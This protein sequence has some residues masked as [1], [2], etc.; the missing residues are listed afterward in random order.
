MPKWNGIWTNN[1]V[2]NLNNLRDATNYSGR[3]KVL[4][5][6]TMP[7]FLANRTPL[8]AQ[9]TLPTIPQALP[10]VVYLQKAH[11]IASLLGG[12]PTKKLTLMVYYGSSP[13]TL[14]AWA[15]DATLITEQGI[16]ID[17]LLPFTRYYYAIQS[18]TEILEG[19]DDNFLYPTYAPNRC[20]LY[21]CG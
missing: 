14:T 12:E 10:R 19:N 6:I 2:V 13:K 11:P 15:K 16:K 4:V 3:C 17:D 21:V 20:N 7:V 18:D 9:T 1:N 5:P 8:L